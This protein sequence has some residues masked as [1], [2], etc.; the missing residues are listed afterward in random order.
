MGSDPGGLPRRAVLHGLLGGLLEGDPRR[1]TLGGREGVGADG[2][3][4]A[5]EPD[6]AS[7]RDAFRAADF[8]VLEVITDARGV[9]APLH[10]SFQLQ[11]CAHPNTRHYPGVNKPPKVA[12]SLTA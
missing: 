9:S 4:R 7:A 12:R 8:I 2:A 11:S 1:A 5:V 10:L 3:R 6:F